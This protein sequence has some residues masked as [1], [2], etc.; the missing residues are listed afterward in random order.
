MRITKRFVPLQLVSARQAARRL[1]VA[2]AWLH[3]QIQRRTIVPDALAGR[4]HVFYEARI[5]RLERK[6]Q[7]IE[8]S[9][10]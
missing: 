9:W 4:T 5:A 7:R 3:R 6:L 8:G 1:H 10:H 2:T